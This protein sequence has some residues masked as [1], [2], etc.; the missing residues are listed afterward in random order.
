MQNS[1]V[2]QRELLF[3]FVLSLF[4]ALSGCAHKIEN[5]AR[6]LS[7]ISTDLHSI[8]AAAIVELTTQKSKKGRAIILASAPDAFRIT[9]KGPIGT[10]IASISGNKKVLTFSGGGKSANYG[11]YDKR[12]P[13]K[14][15]AAEFVSLLLGNENLPA[16]KGITFKIQDAEGR[17]SIT[18]YQNTEI[19]Y[20]AS[21][22]DYR[23][24][25]GFYIPFEISINGGKYKLLIK[26]I[27]AKA[28]FKMNKNLSKTMR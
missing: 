17:K 1:A 19:L 4:T 6:P 9:I 18:K 25:D 3:I 16:G 24:I 10:T 26:Y 8:K 11:P 5:P 22:K 20:H 28:N 14:I 15:T 13:L 7:D 12:I 27:K 2:K 23:I 21:L